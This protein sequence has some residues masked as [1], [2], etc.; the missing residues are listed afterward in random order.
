MD[1]TIPLRDDWTAYRHQFPYDPSG[2]SDEGHLL[3]AEVV[4]D[5]VGI[6]A[7]LGDDAGEDPSVKIWTEPLTTMP[8]VA[9][10]ITMGRA[11]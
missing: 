8:G 10:H 3:S 7:I 2:A 9:L 4:E 5:G 11:P 6:V 1:W